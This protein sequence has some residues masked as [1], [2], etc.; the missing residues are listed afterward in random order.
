MTATSGAMELEAAT[1]EKLNDDKITTRNVYKFARR[2]NCVHRKSGRKVTAL[3]LALYTALL[4]KHKGGRSASSGME[5]PL[6]LNQRGSGL[7]PT[8][9]C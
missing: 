7:L 8:L 1:G 4:Q 5:Y 3:Y 2:E 6:T 9:S